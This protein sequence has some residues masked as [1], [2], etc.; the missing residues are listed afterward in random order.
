MNANDSLEYI[1]KLATERHYL[2]RLAGRQ[3]LTDEQLSRVHEIE[4]KL[5]QL[6]D[7]HRRELASS[8][9]PLKLNDMPNRRIA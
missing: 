8:R 6:W 2:Y 5:P 3:H 7:Q 4:A 9:R 1:Q